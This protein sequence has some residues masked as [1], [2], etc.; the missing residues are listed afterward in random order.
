MHSN[1]RGL[2]SKTE[3]L[4]ANIGLIKPNIVLLN[5]HGIT[6]KNKID[7]KNY[8]TFTRNRDNKQLGGVSISVDNELKNSTFRVKVGEGDDEFIIVKNESV[9]VHYLLYC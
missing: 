2:K 1:I 4:M 5:E 7:I 6:G 3:S 8:T 9:Q